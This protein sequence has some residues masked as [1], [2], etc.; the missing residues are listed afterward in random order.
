MRKY[1]QKRERNKQT[2]H[3]AAVVCCF[4]YSVSTSTASVNGWVWVFGPCVR[5]SHQ[6]NI[7]LYNH[8]AEIQSKLVFNHVRVVENQICYTPIFIRVWANDAF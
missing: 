6:K 3:T 1:I 2:S 5:N 8:L 7:Y 4:P